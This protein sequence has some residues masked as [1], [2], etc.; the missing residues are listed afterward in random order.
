M[1]GAVVVVVGGIRGF[2]QARDKASDVRIRIQ[3]I[4]FPMEDKDGDPDPG[5][6][7]IHAIDQAGKRA[8]QAKGVLFDMVGVGFRLLI[9]ERGLGDL[10]V[11]PS[12][13]GVDRH[14]GQGSGSAGDL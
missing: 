1:V 5:G 3:E 8:E 11:V 10:H 9:V 6:A 14:A 12:G 7:G 2:G 4:V 13:E